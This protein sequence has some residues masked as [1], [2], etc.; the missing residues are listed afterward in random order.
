MITVHKYALPIDDIVSIN[1][2]DDPE[3]L[4][5]AVQHDIVV[6]WV[7]VDTDRF[8]KPRRFR[9]AGTGHADADGKYVGT[10]LLDGGALV[11]HVFDLDHHDPI[12]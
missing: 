11:F 1:M 7:R 3:P 12:F 5:V 9:V 8:V 6:M 2:P 10:V 4:C